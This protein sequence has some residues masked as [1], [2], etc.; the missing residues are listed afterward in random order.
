MNRLEKTLF[1]GPSATRIVEYITKDCPSP[2]KVVNTVAPGIGYSAVT[3][4]GA[5][6]G[7]CGK[8]QILPSTP[9]G[10]HERRSR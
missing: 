2:A 3:R 10:A 5:Q 6:D 8:I 1:T 4:S 7:I 9:L